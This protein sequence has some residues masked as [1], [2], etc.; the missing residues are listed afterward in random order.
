MNHTVRAI[1]NDAAAVARGPWVFPSRTGVTAQETRNYMHRVFMPALKNTGIENFCWH[2]LRHTF[3]SRIVMAGVDLR[4]VQEL[5]GHKSIEMT[6]RYA[7]LSPEHQLEAVQ[8]L[9]RRQATDTRADTGSD[10]VESDEPADLA[11]PRIL[12]DLLARLEGFE[13]PTLRSVARY[14]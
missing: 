3:A 2:D 12:K 1:V 8:R 10:V 9:D 13:P 11:T 4:T 6:L 7:H 5:M 14:K